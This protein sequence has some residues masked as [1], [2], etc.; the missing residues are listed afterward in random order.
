MWRLGESVTLLIDMV[1]AWG[2]NKLSRISRTNLKSL[3]ITT[4][5]A[6]KYCLLKIISTSTPKTA[7]RKRNSLPCL[8]GPDV[9]LSEPAAAAAAAPTGLGPCVGDSTKSSRRLRFPPARSTWKTGL[10]QTFRNL[11]CLTVEL[12]ILGSFCHKL[13]LFGLGSY[14]EKNTFS[15]KVVRNFARFWCYLLRTSQDLDV[16]AKYLETD[17]GFGL[18]LP[19][20]RKTNEQRSLRLFRNTA[21]GNC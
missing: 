13:L 12:S 8:G 6:N 10:E 7:T 18:S 14:R 11:W 20:G 19:S 3:N 16:M 1:R 15:W 5:P 21:S 9:T 2:V 17:I 4:T